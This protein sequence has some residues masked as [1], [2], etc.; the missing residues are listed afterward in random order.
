MFGNSNGR[1][2]DAHR[3]SVQTMSENTNA[4][5]AL[6]LVPKKPPGDTGQ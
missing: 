6:C 2:D 1:I 3:V 5:L 4:C